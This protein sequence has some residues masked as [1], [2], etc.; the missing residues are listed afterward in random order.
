MLNYVRLGYWLLLYDIGYWFTYRPQM[1][2]TYLDPLN[3]E[4]T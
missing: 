4:K 3:Y 2:T 1:L